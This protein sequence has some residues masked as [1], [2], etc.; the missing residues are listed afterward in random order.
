MMNGPIAIHGAYDDRLVVL[1]VLIAIFASYAA[2][3][4][5]GRVTASRGGARL[6]WLTGGA[7]A[8]GSGIWAMHYTGMLAFRLP[9]PVYYHIPTVALS[10]LAAILASAIALFVVSRPRVTAVH[11]G[12]GSALMGA[13]IATMHYTGMAAMRLA[14]MHEYDRELVLISV[15]LAVVIAFAALN[16]T[17]YV[18]NEN[19]GRWLQLGIA[20]VMGLAIPAMHYTG[21]AAVS[22]VSTT[23]QPDLS[24]AVDISTLSSSA[25]ILVTLVI[26]GFA[27]FTSVVDRRL[28]AQARELAFSE[29]RYQLLFESNPAPVLVFDVQT[30]VFLAANQAAVL[31]YGFSLQEFL[32]LKVT[33]LHI[34]DDLE[35]LLSEGPAR[36]TCEAQHRRK[37]GAAI[38]VELR[39]CRITWDG[40]PAAL[41]L[42]HDITER[43]QAERQRDI[44]EVQLRQSQKLE[45]IGQ[46]AAGLAHEINT[47]TQYIGNNVRFLQEAFEELRGLMAEYD[48]QLAA[49]SGHVLSPEAMREIAAAAEQADTSYLLEEIPK[50]IQQTMDGVERV[51]TLVVA[52][53]EF[54]HPGSKEKSP[55]NLNKAI[56]STVIVARN[57]WKYVADLETDYDASMPMILCLPSEFNQAMLN[58]I[59]NAAHA[60]GDVVRKAGSGKG[61]IRVQTL[62]CADW[63]EIRITD[64]GTGIPEKVRERI[65][66]PFFTTKE[67]GRGTGQGLAIVR[68]VIVDKH[69]GSIHFETEEGKGTTFIVR[70]PHDGKALPKALAL[71]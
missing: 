18:R 1:S 58:L 5:T 25:M 59:V 24:R 28:S 30:L 57:E 16:L 40:K 53:K 36:K 49:A 17:Y 54:S 56:E 29:Q 31:T 21:M 23:M 41:L 50:A 65:F 15:L 69:S 4:L 47:P 27:V 46:L 45:S 8:M 37:D 10:L 9:I 34:S 14:A 20:L 60:I 61:K 48:R 7:I 35:S 67:V 26:L 42:V 19:R 32:G 6:A 3:D 68:S 71:A 38:E 63:A 52:M 39:M 11:V 64:T 43:K 44:M 55:L 33:A 13:G 2:L 62:N 51:R 66:D 22:F 70:I 12:A